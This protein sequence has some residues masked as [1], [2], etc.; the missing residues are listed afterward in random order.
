MVFN[1]L[2]IILILIII[3]NITKRDH[4]EHFNNT[5]V[6]E[7]IFNNYYNNQLR[8]INNIFSFIKSYNTN[9]SNIV[10]NSTTDLNNKILTTND[11][12]IKNHM[13][14]KKLHIKGDLTLSSN[15]KIN[16]NAINNIIPRY[17]IIAWYP[18]YKNNYKNQIIYNKI[19]KG[20]VLC[21]GKKYYLDENNNF[22]L[23]TSTFT[24]VISD[25]IETPDLVNKI[26]VGTNPISYT[27]NDGTKENTIKEKKFKSSN[28][29]NLYTLKNSD[30]P[31]HSHNYSTS[32]VYT[33]ERPRRYDINNTNDVGSYEVSTQSF[34][35]IAT[36]VVSPYNY[37]KEPN[38]KTKTDFAGTGDQTAID[39]S[40]PYIKLLYIMKL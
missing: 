22:K 9:N 18:K 21:D 5:E 33:P 38:T 36:G 14:L 8:Y 10:I 24:N 11:L 13:K 27:W 20:W 32:W 3:Y 34:S 26:I 37:G 29:S 25:I 12:N 17:T 6:T 7:D 30:L 28:N 31:I 23:Y 2:I 15:L 39:R 4:N 16:T 40:Q 1:I 19:P 35:G